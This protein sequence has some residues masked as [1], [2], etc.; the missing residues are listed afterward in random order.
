MPV[1][2]QGRVVVARQLPDDALS[3]GDD[4][5]VALMLPAGLAATPAQAVDWLGRFVQAGVNHILLN[6]CYEHESQMEI[7]ATKVVPQL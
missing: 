5:R 4:D 1:P 3:G 7:L 2:V 6:P